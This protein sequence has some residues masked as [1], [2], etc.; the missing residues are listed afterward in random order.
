MTSFGD[1]IR[2]A[3]E[4]KG[5]ILRQVSAIV[6]IDQAIISKFERGERK[7]TKDQ[8]LKF[9]KI[10]KIDKDKLM[11][12]WLSDKVIYE[13]QDEPLAIE[14]L[15]VAEEIIQNKKDIK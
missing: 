1:S 10:L 14:A 7:P 15:Q 4:E 3:R 8:V 13:L 2:R 6:H 5:L 12:D 9:A 11:I